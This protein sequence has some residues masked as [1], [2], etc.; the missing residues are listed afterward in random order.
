[1]QGV[2]LGGGLRGPSGGCGGEADRGEKEPDQGDR[3]GQQGS[4]PLGALG[5]CV[6]HLHR[7]SPGTIAHQLSCHWWRAPPLGISGLPLCEPTEP[8]PRAEK[9][10]DKRLQVLADESL[11]SDAAE[12]H[13]RGLVIV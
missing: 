9:A 7:F 10:P 13:L 12:E 4:L 11:C 5:D 3:C 8:L 2:H 6:D 1:M